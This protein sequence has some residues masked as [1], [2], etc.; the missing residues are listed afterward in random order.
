M[1]DQKLFL[2]GLIRFRCMSIVDCE[3]SRFHMHTT[4]RPK[5][6]KEIGKREKYVI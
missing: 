2:C 1:I 6:P 5:S 3:Y 4:Y